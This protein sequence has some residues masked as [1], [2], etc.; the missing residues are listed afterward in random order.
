M[1]DVDYWRKLTWPAAPNEQDRDMFA[2][3]CTGSVLLLGSTQ[4]LLPI[5]DQAWDLEPAY[6]DPKLVRRDWFDLDQHFDTIIIDGALS[7]GKEFTTRLLPIVLANCD[8][9]VARVFLRT[10]W[11]ARYAVYFPRTHEL[12]PQPQEIEVNDVYSFYIWNK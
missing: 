3:H 2:R 10:T 12:T 6:D 4:L 8:R 1:K 5:C 11:P 9:F 7:F